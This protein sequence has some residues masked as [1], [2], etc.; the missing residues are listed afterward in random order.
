MIYQQVTTAVRRGYAG[1]PDV[2]AQHRAA[3]NCREWIESLD[4]D[5]TLRETLAEPYRALED[6]FAALA[7]SDS[8]SGLLG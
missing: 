8:S 1:H 6:A 7:R 3:R 2:G 5:P 4:I